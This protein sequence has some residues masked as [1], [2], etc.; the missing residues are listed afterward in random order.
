MSPLFSVVLPTFQRYDFAIQAVE[1]VLK[2]DFH[3]F[4]LIIV[5]DH[6]QDGSFEKLE[7]YVEEIQQI[8][9]LR[10]KENME[11]GAS[12]NTGI[13]DSKGQYISFLDSDDIWQ[14]N[15]LSVLKEEIEESSPNIVAT[16]YILEDLVGNKIREPLLEPIMGNVNYQFFLTG[17][18]IA[19]NFTIKND[20]K[21]LTL[22]E[23]SKSLSGFEDWIFL[24]SNSKSNSLLI[25]DQYTVVM[26]DHPDRSMRSDHHE[27]VVKRLRATNR[28][29]DTMALSD[30]EKNELWAGTNYFNSVHSY[31]G[32]SKKESFKYLLKS[33]GGGIHLNHF[34]QAVRIMFL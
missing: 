16:K 24:I 4:E 10:N 28:I 11:R 15:H 18:P 14:S 26:S 5:D 23:E 13:R 8:R 31:L 21:N 19:C 27:L 1:S 30:S 34:K 12:R 29:I 17:N 32:R 20:L 25:I 9:L 7:K 2:Q 3:D 6:S 33:L 22:F